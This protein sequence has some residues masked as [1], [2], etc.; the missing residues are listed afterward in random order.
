MIDWS[1]D[2]LI[3]RFARHVPPSFAQPSFVPDCAVT[4]KSHLRRMNAGG[5]KCVR[6][7]RFLSLF[8]PLSLFNKQ[9]PISFLLTFLSTHDASVGK[10][11][12]HD[13]CCNKIE[14]IKARRTSSNRILRNERA[15]N[16][17]FF[18]DG[19]SVSL[20]DTICDA[21][22]KTSYSRALCA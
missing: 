2:L 1:I 14:L 10:I 19:D 18:Y 7:A 11:E 13:S 9:L 12:S 6:L 15:T 5:S 8:F 20:F 16:D 22:V 3:D 21:D 4:Y 17:I